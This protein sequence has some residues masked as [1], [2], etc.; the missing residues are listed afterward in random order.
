[1]IVTDQADHAP[2][3]RWVIVFAAA[4]MLAIAMGLLVN[5]LSV[6]FIPLEQEYGWS[7]GSISL[8]NTIG[9]V[10][11]AIGGIAMG[12]IADRS[13]K[14][15]VCL[16][17]GAVLGVCVLAAAW[18]DALWQLYVLFFFAGAFGGGSL[19]A[20]LVAL[21]GNW[22][23]TGAG[24]AIGIAS[25]GQA[26]GQGGVPFGTTFLI[27]TLGW[28]GAIAALGMI[29]LA[30]LVPLALLIKEP[31]VGADTIAN[32]TNSTV[33]LSPTAVVIWLSAAV[34]FCCTCMSV[35][36][37]HLVPLCQGQ[38]ISASE[39]GS[40]LFIVLIVA[41]LG[42]VAFG[43]LADIIGAIPAYMTASLWQTVLVYVFT[44][45]NDLS[46]MYLFAPIYGFGYAGV[47]TGLLITVRAVTPASRRSSSIGVII[48]FAWL[49]H[50][51]GGYEGGLFFDLTGAYNVSFAIAALAGMIN[52]IIV[53]SLYLTLRRRTA[54]MMSASA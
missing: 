26:V 25:A 33:P 6:F 12:P 27:E 14:K 50:G 37:M 38:G 28:R 32:E 9:L 4:A 1:L 35:P 5:G 31:P 20:P 49:G 39:A 30:T 34:I 10:G 7:R 45:I 47:M 43:R 18:A 21:V 19:F 48:A 42:R 24:L 23:R 13:S 54:S 44:Q 46:L 36:L 52:L 51:I 2:N 53:G 15:K 16:F 17:G 11:L 8:I 40:V 3:Y 29:S 22:F 41:I